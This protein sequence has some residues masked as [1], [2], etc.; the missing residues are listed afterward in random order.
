MAVT[1]QLRKQ[2]KGRKVYLSSQFQRLQS[3]VDWLHCFGPEMRENI[4]VDCV[5]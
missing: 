1:K 4:V 3:M 2:L 5:M